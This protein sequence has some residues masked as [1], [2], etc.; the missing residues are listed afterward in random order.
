ME[1]RW[2]GSPTPRP[3]GKSSRSLGRSKD[4]A[5]EKAIVLELPCGISPSVGCCYIRWSFRAGRFIITRLADLPAWW[6]IICIGAVAV[7]LNAWLVKEELDWC[8]KDCGAKV[9]VIDQERLD[10][11]GEKGGLGLKDTAA[12]NGGVEHFILV[13]SKIPAGLAAAGISAIPFE[14]LVDPNAPAGLPAADISPY[15]NVMIM[16]SSGTTGRPKGVLYHHLSLAQQAHA[17]KYAAVRTALRTGMDV[18]AN[19]PQITWIL[20]VPLFHLTGIGYSFLGTCAG[21][22]HVYVNKWDASEGIEI[23]HKDKVT[24]FMGVPTQALQLL[25]SPSF[26]KEKL[27]SLV[28]LGYGGA[29]GPAA[30]RSRAKAAFGRPGFGEP[31]N[32]YGATESLAISANSGEDFASKPDS[33]GNPPAYLRVEIRDEDGTVLPPNSVGEIWVKGFGIA[34]G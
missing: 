34:K 5:L 30:L 31:S 21:C 22:R 24:H 11:L 13:R 20:P 28:F 4:W 1:R 19:P 9:L 29:P 7:P 27:A 16:Y 3:R 32:G 26:S 18:P 8:I 14:K 6:A 17:N 33:V 12:P 25:E 2:F 15:D 10:R 23:I